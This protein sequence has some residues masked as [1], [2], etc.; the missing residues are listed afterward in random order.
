[1]FQVLRVIYQ[2]ILLKRYFEHLYTCP[3]SRLYPRIYPP[4]AFI[5][6]SVSVSHD[7]HSLHLV[8]QNLPGALVQRIHL[9]S[10]L[11]LVEGI[12]RLLEVWDGRGIAEGVRHGV[13]DLPEQED[14]PI[15]RHRTKM[16]HQ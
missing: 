11:L 7:T 14:R 8:R 1:M 9:R 10:N 16:S 13:A 3:G 4:L 15:R 12:P 2:T 5:A 6:A